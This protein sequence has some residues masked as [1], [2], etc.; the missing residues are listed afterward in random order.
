P[1]EATV[2]ATYYKV[3]P[4]D[5]LKTSIPIGKPISNYKVYILDEHSQ[6]LPIGVAGELYIGGKGLARGYQNNIE[7]TENKFVMN[8]WNSE[9]KLYRTG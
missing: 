9:E 8:R 2:C 1:T 3:S 5:W 7:L 6:L 4:K